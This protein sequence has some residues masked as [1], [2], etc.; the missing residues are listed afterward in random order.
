MVQFKVDSHLILM[1]NLFYPKCEEIY[2]LLFKR[3][4]ACQPL[5]RL[6]Y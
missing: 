4:I 3:E 6:D 5:L 1:I 2:K